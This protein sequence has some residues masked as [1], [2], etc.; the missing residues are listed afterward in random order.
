[1]SIPEI[2]KKNRPS[3]SDTSI[4]TY[5]SIINGIYKKLNGEGDPTQKFFLENVDKVM[6]YLHDV[7]YNTRKTKLASL[8]SLCGDH[9]CANQYR[10]IMNKDIQTYN[11]NEKKQSMTETQKRNWISQEDL[12]K[13]YNDLYKDSYHLFKKE[14]LTKTELMRLQ[15]FLTLSLYVLIP[16][17][18]ITDYIK[19]KLRNYTEED[20]HMGKN[21]TMVFND[22]KTRKTYG[23]QTISINSKLYNII[24]KW[25]KKHDNDFLLFGENGKPLTAPQLTLRLNKILGKNASV[26]ALRHSFITENVLKD[27]PKLSEMEKVAEEMGNSTDQQ[28]LYVKR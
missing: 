17:R 8:V 21:K 26:N 25:E 9:Q 12:K 20:N 14:R 2:L 16:P 19:F 7:P 15:N 3:I 27:M 1:M 24:K 6:E 13:I 18:R 23:V 28:I 22:F 10:E 4:K 11:A 5:N